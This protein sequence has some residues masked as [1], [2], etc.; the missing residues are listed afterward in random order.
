MSQ[1]SKAR[2][3]CEH[4]RN[5]S[6]GRKVSNAALK[7]GI[8]SSGLARLIPELPKCLMFVDTPCAN[9]IVSNSFHFAASARESKLVNPGFTPFRQHF[10]ILGLALPLEA[11]GF[12][13][14][15]KTVAWPHVSADIG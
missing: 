5:G 2:R 13:L 1:V 6:S 12:L 3:R 10:T 4:T 11:N 7:I 8:P 9:C 15:A 14:P